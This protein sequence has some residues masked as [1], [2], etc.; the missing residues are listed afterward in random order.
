MEPTIVVR[1]EKEYGKLTAD[2]FREFIG[3]LPE[4][5]HQRDEFGGFLAE[6]PNEKFDELMVSG[7]NWSLVYENAFAWHISIAL[8]AFNQLKW[9]K[10]I[11]LAPDP[12]QQRWIRGQTPTVRTPN[13]IPT[14]APLTLASCL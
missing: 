14:A 11:S 13:P 8:V 1:A 5:R 3:K 9:M 12:Q 7:N 4:L 10:D 6:L 2:Q